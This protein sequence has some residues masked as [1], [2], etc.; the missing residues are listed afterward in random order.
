MRKLFILRGVMGSGKSTFIKDNNLGDY[1]LNPDKIRLMLNSLEMTTDYNEM[2]PQFNNTKVWDFLYSTLEERMKKGELAIVDAMHIYNEDYK[3]YKSMAETYRY[4]LYVIDFTDVELEVLL[5]RNKTRE[6]IKRVPNK[7]IEKLYKALKKETVPKAFKNIKPEDFYKIVGNN[8]K[9]VDKYNKVHIFGDI[10]ACYEPLKE[11]FTKDKVSDNEL[12]IFTGDYVDRGLDNVK[13]LEFIKDNIS[14][15]NFIFLMGNHEDRLYKYL[16]NGE[17]KDD[18]D[19]K[20]TLEELKGSISFSEIRGI[21][22]GLAQIAN[23]EYKGKRYIINHAGIS[24]YPNKPLDFYST[25]T[26]LYGVGKYEDDIDRIYN[27]Y[28]LKQDNKV[29]QVHGHRN[30]NK[31]KIDEYEYSYNLD[32]DIEFGGSLR[33]LVLNSDGTINIKEIENKKYDSKLKEKERVYDLVNN[34]RNNKYIIEKELDN[35]ISSFNFTK[36][37]FYNRVWNNMT[38]KARGLFI[39]TNN[40][41][42]V[43]RSY[44]KFF[45]MDEREE[46]KYDKLLDKIAYPVSFYMKYNGF[47]GILSVYNDELIFGTK[48]LLSGEYS[49]YFKNI[50]YKI[51]TN[52]QIDSI[53]KRLIDNNSSLVFEVIDSI[54]DKHIIEYKEDNLVLLDE[55]VNSIDYKKIEY[56][57]LEKFAKKNKVDIKKLV[58]TSNTKEEFVDI[59]DKISD[60]DYKYNRKYVEGFVLEDNSGFMIKKKTEYYKRWKTIRTK[61]ETALKTNKYNIKTNDDLEKDFIKYIE[62]KYKDK[63][64]DIKS[65]NIIDERNNFYK[66][67]K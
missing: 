35:N 28:I 7:T 41:L 53:K 33:V 22:K 25:N 43:A 51:Y 37:A 62:D 36:E 17:V 21:I 32:G 64:I 3:I 8:F 31:I 18:Y 47:L 13:V 10:H 34:L 61:M 59:I 55:I 23:I 2:I 19:L 39:D 66:N 45:N 48:S 56:S 38:T 52:K 1:T 63:E 67:N 27:E 20:K 65:I 26:Y 24:Y 6:E 46:V 50:F 49:D 15:D 16:Y 11:Y 60:E 44:D 54:N 57:E 12:Y 4:R 30:Y 5:Q 14:K 29:Y 9:N 40:Y 42:V 58:Y